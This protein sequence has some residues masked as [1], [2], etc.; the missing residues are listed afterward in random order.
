MGMLQYWLENDMP[1][2]PLEMAGMMESIL[3]RGLTALQ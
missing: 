3:V 2:S 1:L